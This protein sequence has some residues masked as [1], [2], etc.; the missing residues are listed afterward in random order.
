MYEQKIEEFQH[1]IKH[2]QSLLE[3]NI[4]KHGEEMKRALK[5]SQD[6]KL[7]VTQKYEKQIEMIQQKH[8]E[9]AEIQKE[10]ISNMEKDSQL[11]LKQMQLVQ[12]EIEKLR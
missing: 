5:V 12:E 6:E 7:E 3:Q 10:Y 9:F 2:Y 8:N 11:R 4:D 1:N